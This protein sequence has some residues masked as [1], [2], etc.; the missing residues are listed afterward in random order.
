MI[1]NIVEKIRLKGM[2]VIEF[3]EFISSLWASSVWGNKDYLVRKI[4]DD[5]GIDKIRTQFGSLLYGSD[6]FENRFGRFIG[7]IKGLGPA[8]LTEISCL[9]DPHK[10]S[11]WNDKTRKAL[12][13]LRFDSIVSNKC[14]IDL[15]H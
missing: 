11:I 1:I 6:S 3:G 10:Y 9:F 7:E 4:I 13:H 15:P 5:N 2:T 14:Q 8:S 12:R